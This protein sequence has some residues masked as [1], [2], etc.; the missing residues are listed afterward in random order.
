MDGEFDH[1]ILPR[2]AMDGRI[3]EKPACERGVSGSKDL[4]I[5]THVE[6]VRRDA[7]QAG[8][9]GNQRNHPG[10]TARKP[11]DIPL[12]ASKEQR[13]NGTP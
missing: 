7:D 11:E 3:N 4:P 2:I 1:P 6:P 13:G 10:S 9:P 12:N 8:R 5:E